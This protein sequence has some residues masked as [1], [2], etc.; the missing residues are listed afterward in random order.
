[1]LFAGRTIVIDD[2]ELHFVETTTTMMMMISVTYD[3][4]GPNLV[5]RGVM[6]LVLDD[7]EVVDD[8]VDGCC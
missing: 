3:D 4:F 2:D 5:L 1:M 7:D 6:T 8:V